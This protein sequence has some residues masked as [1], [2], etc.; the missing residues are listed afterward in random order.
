[1][2]RLTFTRQIKKKLF[3]L[4]SLI[5]FDNTLNAD[6]Y[7]KIYDIRVN[8]HG[9]FYLRV[10][11]FSCNV[12]GWILDHTWLLNVLAGELSA[13]IW[14]TGIV[15]VTLYCLLRSL[16]NAYNNI[17]TK[18]PIH[19]PKTYYTRIHKAQ[20]ASFGNFCSNTQNFQNFELAV[21]FIVIYYMSSYISLNSCKTLS[22]YRMRYFHFSLSV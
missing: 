17:L 5:E 8:F 1:M 9:Y 10:E 18:Q 21:F 6:I 19:I 3:L 2:S 4:F 11:D 15:S 20:Y 14:R 16:I 22:T 12:S 7:L 13:Y